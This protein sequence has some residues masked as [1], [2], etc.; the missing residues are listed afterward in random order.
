MPTTSV[1]WPANVARRDI[2]SSSQAPSVSSPCASAISTLTTFDRSSCGVTASES[3][4][5]VVTLA[6][7]QDP[8]GR[9]SSASPDG[10]AVNRGGGAKIVFLLFVSPL[11]TKAWHGTQIDL[12]QNRKRPLNAD[13][14]IDPSL[15]RESRRLLV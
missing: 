2:F 10:V 13:D 8:P 6:A 14:R 3:A 11:T 9:N 12:S 15:W 5:R 1:R 4:S 7:V